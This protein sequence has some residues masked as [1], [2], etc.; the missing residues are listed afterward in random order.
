MKGDSQGATDWEAVP[1]DPD[2]AS[3]LG[4]RMLE[5]DVVQTSNDAEQLI[6]LPSDD[7]LLR[8]DAFIVADPDDVCD[9]TAQR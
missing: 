5:W 9:V 8:D 7:E 3:D 4:Y 1:S 6:F 2:P